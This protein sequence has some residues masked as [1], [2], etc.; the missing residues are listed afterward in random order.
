[1]NIPPINLL[2][3]TASYFAYMWVEICEI[4][5]KLKPLKNDIF[6]L[7]SRLVI[8]T[9]LTSLSGQANLNP[10]NEHNNLARYIPSLLTIHYIKQGKE[11]WTQ[12]FFNS[13]F[14][15]H[16]TC[17]WEEGSHYREDAANF[18]IFWSSKIYY[19]VLNSFSKAAILLS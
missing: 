16:V 4:V 3:P 7:Q 2:M 19:N 13:W 14:I 15:L 6:L 12:T 18:H 8:N 11:L 1:M 10:M 9:S 5:R 17:T